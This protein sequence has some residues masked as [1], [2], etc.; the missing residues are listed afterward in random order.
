MKNSIK[1][2]LIALV[3]PSFLTSCLDREPEK[4]HSTEQVDSPH[5]DSLKIDTNELDSLTKK[6]DSTAQGK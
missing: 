4:N 6:T 5:T 2:A 3:I 1:A